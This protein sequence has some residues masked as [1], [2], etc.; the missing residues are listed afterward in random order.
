MNPNYFETLFATT[1]PP[2]WPR[3]FAIITAWQPTGE[4]WTEERS[5]E[6]NARLLESLE[7]KHA[8]FH[9]VTGYSPTTE[10]A[11]PGW[12]VALTFDEACDLG[13]SFDQDAIYYIREDAL[14]VSHCDTRRALIAVGSFRERVRPL[15]D[16][17]A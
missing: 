5:R 11:E 8:W 7:E 14:F 13:A 10:H 17:P 4:S 15:L 3:E 9:P 2:T 6:A 12:A 16:L 1:P